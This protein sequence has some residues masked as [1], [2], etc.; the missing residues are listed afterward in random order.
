MLATAGCA[1]ALTR[2]FSPVRARGDSMSPAIAPG[3]LLAVRPLRAGEPRAGQVVVAHA[4][5]LEVVKRVVEPPPS[6]TLGDGEH[7][8]AGDHA[9][10]STDSR[11]MGPVAR[12]NISAV[13]RACYWPPRR[14]RLFLNGREL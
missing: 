12:R 11:T 13:V 1:F 10:R 8:L 9:E 5:E 2:R 4:G 7:W 3:D 14:W 6:M